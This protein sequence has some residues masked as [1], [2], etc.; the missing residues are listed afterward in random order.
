MLFLEIIGK[1]FRKEG[2][3]FLSYAD[4]CRYSLSRLTAQP[5]LWCSVCRCEIYPQEAYYELSGRAVCRACLKEHCLELLSSQQ[6]FA[7]AVEV[8]G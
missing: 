8:D 6:R 5:A 2:N 1:Y 7:P 4:I 3:G